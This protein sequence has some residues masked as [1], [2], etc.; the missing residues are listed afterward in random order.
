MN[1]TLQLNVIIERNGR[2]L[3]CKIELPYLIAK[4]EMTF[5]SLIVD[6]SF[7][8]EKY[9]VSSGYAKKVLNDIYEEELTDKDCEEIL[10]KYRGMGLMSGEICKSF[11]NIAS[12]FV[13]HCLS[14]CKIGNNGKLIQNTLTPTTEQAMYKM[15]ENNTLLHEIYQYKKEENKDIKIG[16]INLV[17]MQPKAI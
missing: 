6:V 5:A 3:K 11:D 9:K 8:P 1:D 16:K 15:L 14:M 12:I 4:K 2:P 7:F 17:T 13:K 10:N